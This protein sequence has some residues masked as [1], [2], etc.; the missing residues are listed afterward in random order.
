MLTPLPDLPIVEILDELRAALT[1]TTRVV[2]AAPPG[3]G[4]TTVVPLALRDETWL[5]DGR[6]VV[7]EPRRLATRAAARRMADLTRTSVGGLVGYQT[8]DERH[9]GRDT[10]IEV[11]T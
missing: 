2:V 11:V 1:A 3:A 5:G 9:I 10:R 4:K 7:L 6:I 8:R